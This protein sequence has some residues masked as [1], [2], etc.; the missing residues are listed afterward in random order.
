MEEAHLCTAAGVAHFGDGAVRS[1]AR[2]GSH[3]ETSLLVLLLSRP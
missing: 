3:V 1:F 2:R